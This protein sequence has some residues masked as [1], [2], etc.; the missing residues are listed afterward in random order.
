MTGAL[1]RTT[2]NTARRETDAVDERVDQRH[3]GR[4]W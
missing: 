4:R 1:S 2:A 3:D